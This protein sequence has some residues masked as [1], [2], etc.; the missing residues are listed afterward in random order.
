MD[1]QSAV[2]TRH[3]GVFPPHMGLVSSPMPH[4][5]LI[6]PLY[7]LAQ[8]GYPSLPQDL[9]TPAQ[10]LPQATTGGGGGLSKSKSWPASVSTTTTAGVPIQPGSGQAPETSSH[11]LPAPPSYSSVMSALVAPMSHY[12]LLAGNFY[13]QL[14]ALTGAEQVMA[15][16]AFP[17]KAQMIKDVFFTDAVAG[18]D[19]LVTHLAHF[20]DEGEAIPL[21]SVF[22]VSRLSP[23]S[24]PSRL[25]HEDSSSLF[26]Y[27]M[28]T[29]CSTPSLEGDGD[30]FSESKLGQLDHGPED[31]LRMI[32]PPPQ[33]YQSPEGEVPSRPDSALSAESLPV[34]T[35]S[36][37]QMGLYFLAQPQD[38]AM[39]VPS[40]AK[41]QSATS[42]APPP[43][44]GST[45]TASPVQT[46]SPR[47]LIHPNVQSNNPLTSSTNQSSVAGHSAA[48][49]TSDES[50]YDEESDDDDYDAREYLPKPPS[51]MR[52]RPQLA[53]KK[54]RS[55][56][57]AGTK[58]R[59]A[60]LDSEDE[61]VVV[62][63]RAST[64]APPSTTA[65]CR[66][67]TPEPQPTPCGCAPEN[68]GREVVQ[69]RPTQHPTLYETLTQTSID[70]CRYCGTTEGINWRPGPWGKRTLCNKHGCDYKGYGFACKLPRLDLKAYASES[71]EE[72]DR[73]V[74]Q[75][76]C[77]ACHDSR[78]YSG[79]VMVRCEGCP[80]A[81]HQQCFP[82]GI[83]DSLVQG[84]GVW[85]C[86]TSCPANC[87]S[88]RV[89]VELP[90]KRLP[91]MCTPRAGGSTAANVAA[92][93]G[94][95]SP[96]SPNAEAER[97]TS[98]RVSSPQPMPTANSQSN[99]GTS[100]RAAP[101]RSNRRSR[102][103]SSGFNANKSDIQ[104]PP[105][106]SPSV[107]EGDA[108]SPEHSVEPLMAANL[109][110]PTTRGRPTGT[111]KRKQQQALPTIAE[112]GRA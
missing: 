74:L 12:P 109:S 27:D 79:N 75:L 86:D 16:T 13:P 112:S 39:L 82:G 83:P 5:G 54:S 97:S 41:Y 100:V 96:V 19:P 49:D 88:K 24:S 8:L 22:E 59:R 87:R 56:P 104:L 98:R 61:E 57:L 1:R 101:H 28:D 95:V 6:T 29:V 47:M 106:P 70:W 68:E 36:S 53:L 64:P 20:E 3:P 44:F 110:S 60:V 46:V 25:D 99:S 52:G 42:F 92:V 76:F 31:H 35:S 23:P 69:A 105:S 103:V 66:L 9:S 55:T 84:N 63:K 48:D 34:A 65:T 18:G 71:I 26:G 58:R 37:T 21:K 94:L 102:R 81:Y 67:V 40:S 72:R 7:S 108:P 73:P 43:Y 85:Y 107:G 80:K 2:Y 38:M 30:L 15:T 90:R 77:T 93:G 33:E 89:V 111:K 45:V 4:H 10:S 78:S 50:I 11:S 51:G 32:T 14:P 17:I 62:T 91:L